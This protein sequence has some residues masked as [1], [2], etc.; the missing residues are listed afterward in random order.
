MDLGS[1]LA[2]AVIAVARAVPDAI[3]VGRPLVDVA[4]PFTGWLDAA[5]VAFIVG[6]GRADLHAR[7]RGIAM[8]AFEPTR[9]AAQAALDRFLPHAG[10][11][12][13]E[14]RSFDFGPDRRDNISVLS[15][16]IRHRIISE[17]EVVAAVLRAHS[18][19]NAEK[20]VQEVFWRTYWKGWLQQRPAIWHDYLVELEYFKTQT[21]DD[22][23]TAC[24]GETGI[25]C[26]DHWVH[27][28]QSTGYLHNHARMWFAS[29]WI[30]TLRL[31]WQLGADFFLRNLADGDP[32]SNTLSWRWVAGLQ[33]I[34]KHYVASAD[35]IERYTGGR[36]AKPK[37]AH[38]AEPLPAVA[39]PD[40]VAIVPIRQPQPGRYALLLT[41][42]DMYPL[43]VLPAGVEIAGVA[44]IGSRQ[45]CAPNIAEF[46][47]AALQN[48]C[49][50]ISVNFGVAAKSIENWNA[51]DLAYWAKECGVTDILTAEAPV[52]FV[53][54]YLKRMVLDLAVHDVY[55]HLFRRR[56][57]ELCWPHARKGF[58]GFKEKIPSIIGELKL[59]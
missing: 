40:P 41:E 29:I 2:R 7:N 58:F 42:E 14:Q 26:F 35:N 18:P 57:D 39:H 49:N 16:Y 53:A 28:L 13:A 15:P 33:T 11:Q 8:T 50:E 31:P 54:P 52:G 51:Q 21:I 5:A 1:R 56:W 23:A 43:H 4:M 27:E 36:F 59:L 6:A 24:G 20:F 55:L 45:P 30:F 48:A 9:V 10:R 34:G 32:A 17:Q 44:S 3:A 47:R 25:E 46:K 19:A 12:Y 38:H 37:L 22:V